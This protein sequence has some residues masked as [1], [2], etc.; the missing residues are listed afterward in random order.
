MLFMPLRFIF[1]INLVFC[2]NCLSITP[3]IPLRVPPQF[4]S[5]GFFNYVFFGFKG[6]EMM[7]LVSGINPEVNT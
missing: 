4:P 5:E 3:F 2:Q 1:H 6:K 7:F